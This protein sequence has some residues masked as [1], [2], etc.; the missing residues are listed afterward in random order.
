MKQIIKNLKL[1]KLLLSSSSILKEIH[2]NIEKDFSNFIFKDDIIFTFKS[3]SS[4][5]EI[6][7]KNFFTLLMLSILLEAKV[8]TEKIVSYGKI[9]IFLRQIVTSTDNIIDNEEKG[10]IVFK[11]L[12][13]IVVKNN[14]LSL[15]C[16]DLLTK[17]CLKI[18]NG[19]SN[20]SNSIFEELYSIALSESLRDSSLYEKYPSSNYVLN[21]IHS[22]IGGKLLEISLV[23]PK[24]IEKN[25]LLYKYS[26]GLYE[27][28]MSLQAI[29]DLF[30][31]REDIDSSKINLALSKFLEK[32]INFELKNF[33]NLDKDFS[34][35]F[36]KEII[37]S[38]YN[39]FSI[40]RNNGFP[41][42]EHDAKKM[43]KELFKLRG[44]EDYVKVIN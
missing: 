8:S 14:F 12:E 37:K 40:L 38:A 35:C 30:D 39:G 21:K 29:D 28:G 4:Y 7:K 33:E 6:F 16:Q 5:K 3:N 32:N 18:S 43:L 27:I 13:N 15:I 20:V 42:S 41:I 25:M 36:L 9:I 1:A 11:S 2:Q 44:L 24:L 31:V 26:S 17:E 10:T 22:G 23:A 19:D 34:I